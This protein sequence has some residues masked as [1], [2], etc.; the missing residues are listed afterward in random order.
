MAMAAGI[1]HATIN[2]VHCAH[3]DK[4]AALPTTPTPTAPNIGAGLRRDRRRTRAL[5]VVMAL[6]VLRARAARHRATGRPVPAVLLAAVNEFERERETVQ[7]ALEHDALSPG[8]GEAH[9]RPGVTRP[10]S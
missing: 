8:G 9:P 10:L 2:C 5:R 4:E 3:H 1:G 7:D 6:T